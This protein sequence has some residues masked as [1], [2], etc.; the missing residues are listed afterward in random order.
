MFAFMLAVF[1]KISEECNSFSM[2]ASVFPGKDWYALASIKG[3]PV[4]LAVLVVP[5]ASSKLPTDHFLP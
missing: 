5:G 2:L 4:L 1:M 3:L